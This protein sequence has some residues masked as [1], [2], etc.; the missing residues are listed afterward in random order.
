MLVTPYCGT[1]PVPGSVTW[2]LDPTLIAVLCAVA[3]A[4]TAATFHDN[5]QPMRRAAFLGGWALLSLSLISPLCNLSVALF[6]VRVGQHMV[7]EF[8]AAP[9][10]AFGLPR[11]LGLPHPVGAVACVIGF[12]A[13]LWFWHV[14]APYEWTFRSTAAYWMMHLSLAG[15]AVLLWRVLLDV[16]RPGAALIASGITTAQMTL[17][18]AIY[19]FAGRVFF[20]VH[21]GTTEA[22]GL[23]PLEDQQLGGLIMWIPP[24]LMLSAAAVHAIAMQISESSRHSAAR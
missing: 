13:V 1:P 12:T 2:N 9:L 4:Y 21:L 8:I 18:G 15:F 6:S 22:W 11:R 23:S 3:V 10:I 20:D 7:I 16:R 19:T 24:G 5:E 14:P 17:L